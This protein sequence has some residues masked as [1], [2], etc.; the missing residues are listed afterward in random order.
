LG[1]WNILSSDTYNE[2]VRVF[3]KDTVLGI[4]IHRDKPEIYNGWVQQVT[5]SSS[6]IV[7]NK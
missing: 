6:V 3:E 2:R 4:N 1:E 7:L 5:A